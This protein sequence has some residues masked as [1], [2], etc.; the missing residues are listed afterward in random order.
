MCPCATILDG[1][2]EGAIVPFD[3][4]ILLGHIE[5]LNQLAVEHHFEARALESD[6]VFVPLVGFIQL[7]LRSDGRGR[8]RRSVRNLLPAGVAKVGHLEFKA[9]ERRIAAQRSMERAAAVAKF[10]KLEFRIRG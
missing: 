3:L 4:L 9:V 6:L 2:S 8:V 7:L 1:W 10:A 5:I